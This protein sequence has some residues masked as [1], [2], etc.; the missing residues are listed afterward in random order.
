[1]T[2]Y[3][4]IKTGKEDHCSSCHSDLFYGYAYEDDH[5]DYSKGDIIPEQFKYCCCK[6]VQFG[7]QLELLGLLK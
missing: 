2:H 3:V 1:M 6:Q 5:Y 7:K 4:D